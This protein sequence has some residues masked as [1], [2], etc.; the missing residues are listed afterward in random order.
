[1]VR[2]AKRGYKGA[3]WV[4]HSGGIGGPRCPP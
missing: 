3:G 1:V 2:A 4:I